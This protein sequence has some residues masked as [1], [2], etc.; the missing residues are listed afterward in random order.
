MN[1]KSAS[2]SSISTPGA[3]K[4]RRKTQTDDGTISRPNPLDSP[5]ARNASPITPNGGSGGATGGTG[6]GA[7]AGT[8]GGAA[9]SFRNVSACNR[10]RLRKNRC[11]QRLPACQSCEKAGVRC[12]GAYSLH[13]CFPC[14]SSALFPVVW[15][16][17]GR[18]SFLPPHWLEIAID[19]ARAQATTR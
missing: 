10:C 2:P 4:R 8:G 11:D 15:L 19:M 1:S 14:A 16:W 18:G 3:P 6:M 13:L 17:R 7:G 9:S 12:V 5:P